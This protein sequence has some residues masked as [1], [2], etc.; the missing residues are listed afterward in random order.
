MMEPGQPPAKC[1]ASKRALAWRPVGAVRERR[2]HAGGRQG[3][4]VDDTRY[5]PQKQR[6][7]GTWIGSM[8]TYLW[9][10]EGT[11]DA[12][13]KVLTLNAEGPSM[14]TE[15][16]LA[17]TGTHRIQERRP[18]CADVT[19]AERRRRMAPIHDGE[20]RGG[21]SHLSNYRRLGNAI[22]GL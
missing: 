8:M 17:N 1:E 19:H 20:Y 18:S 21:N 11:L 16:K 14:G 2:R 5:D 9:V 6:F 22:H 15:G 4:H 13:E 7:V 10:Y 12:T 3:E